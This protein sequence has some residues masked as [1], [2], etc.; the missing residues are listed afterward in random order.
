MKILVFIMHNLISN[1]YNNKYNKKIKNFY[2]FI[3]LIYTNVYLQYIHIYFFTN[4]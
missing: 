2:Y 4:F 1:L 3:N